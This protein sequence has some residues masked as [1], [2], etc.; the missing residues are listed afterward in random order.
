MGNACLRQ[1]GGQAPPEL[2]GRGPDLWS[3]LGQ[4]LVCLVCVAGSEQPGLRTLVL[5]LA[6]LSLWF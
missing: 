5:Q 2:G 6:E 4:W 1:P 3:D